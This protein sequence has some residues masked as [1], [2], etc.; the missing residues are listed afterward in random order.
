MMSNLRLIPILLAT[1]IVT[2]GDAAPSFCGQK[3]SFE[4]RHIE[5]E[6]T[7]E[8]DGTPDE[9]ISLLE[10]LGRPRWVKSWSFEFL[11]PPSGR[12]II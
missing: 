5:K 3:A 9:V 11:Y 4:A 2:A 8:I 1:L 7:F 10:P 6:A 12:N